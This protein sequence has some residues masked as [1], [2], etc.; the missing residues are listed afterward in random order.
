[1]QVPVDGFKS[2]KYKL[3]KPMHNGIP[4]LPNGAGILHSVS[5]LD[6]MVEQGATLGS[7][8][9]LGSQMSM[10]SQR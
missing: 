7:Q 10:N 8:R 2:R 9:S 5:A 4:I 3:I 6:E 1:M